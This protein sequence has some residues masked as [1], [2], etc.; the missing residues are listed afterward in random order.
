MLINLVKN[1]LH[2][3]FFIYLEV[4]Q[5]PVPAYY[6]DDQEEHQEIYI[7]IENNHDNVNMRC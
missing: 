6:E 1:D 4:L 5:E 7:N 2:E 3:A